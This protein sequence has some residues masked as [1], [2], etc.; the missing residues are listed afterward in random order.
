M[1]PVDPQ[2]VIPPPGMKTF[3]VLTLLP[4]F[5]SSDEL[6]KTTILMRVKRATVYAAFDRKP[7]NDAIPILV[8]QETVEKLNEMAKEGE[9]PKEPGEQKEA[10]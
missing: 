2:A 9:E 6:A 8:S 1:V 5:A 7:P 3:W 4:V 10:E